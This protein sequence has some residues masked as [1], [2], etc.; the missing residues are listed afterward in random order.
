M[1]ELTEFELG[2]K[3][4]LNIFDLIWRIYQNLKKYQKL[5][6]LNVLLVYA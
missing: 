4:I 2:P 1:T 5:S 3:F 6:E